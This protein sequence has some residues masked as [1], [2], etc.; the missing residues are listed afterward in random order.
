MA[1]FSKPLL[2]D[3]YTS[4]QS[5][6]TANIIAALR[7]LDPATSGTHTNVPTG[8]YRINGSAI[9][10]YNGASW[11]AVSLAV[12]AHTHSASD[13]ASG[14]LADAR[15]PATMTAKTFSGT[16]TINRGTN[17]AESTKDLYLQNGSHDLSILARAGV[18][19]FNAIVQAGDKVLTFSNGAPDTAALCIAPWSTGACGIRIDAATGKTTVTGGLESASSVADSAGNLRDLAINTQNAN[20]TFVLADRGKCVLKNNSTAYTWTIPPNSSVA[21][22]IGT[23][24][25][26]RNANASGAV[27]IAR[28][29]GVVLR[30]AGS[31]TDADATL[32]AWGM[33]TLLK[34]GTDSWA[35]SGTGVS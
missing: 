24:I 16:L 29:T 12:S 15:L 13:I 23:M 17:T 1:D 33:A 10:K 5:T 8:A 18:G 4:W 2:T 7:W 32:G 34:E 21:Y 19:A 11:S 28:G 9:E 25:T 27:T 6:L 26:L 30:K 35:I 20:Y 14:T 31:G 3:T 22:P